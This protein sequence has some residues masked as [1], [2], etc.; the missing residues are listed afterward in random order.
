MKKLMLICLFLTGITAAS[1]AQTL[2]PGAKSKEL[3]KDLK[4]TNAQTAKVEA[5]FTGASKKLDSLKTATKGNSLAFEKSVPVLRKST[6]AKIKAVLTPA[7]AAS[8]D[9]VMKSKIAQNK[10][11]WGWAQ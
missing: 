3:Q 1:I 7:Q 8:Y 11:G 6:D 4:L 9:K 10:N 2:S 5:I